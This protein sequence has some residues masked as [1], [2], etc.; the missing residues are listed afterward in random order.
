MNN[1]Q[2]INKEMSRSFVKFGLFII[3]LTAVVFL[4]KTFALGYYK[5]RLYD[6]YENCTVSTSTKTVRG[7]KGSTKTKY[8]VKVVCKDPELLAKNKADTQEG[9]EASQK[10]SRMKVK[11]NYEDHN[12]NKSDNDE[13]AEE[14]VLFSG[15]VSRAYYKHFLNYDDS[16]IAMYT[17]D[18][19]RHF[20]VWDRNCSVTE[21]EKQYRQLD[22]PVLW[23]TL[24]CFGLGVGLFSLIMGI[25]AK[26]T[27][28]NYSNDRVYESEFRFENTE[29][30]LVGMAHARIQR[31]K[32]D[33]YRRRH[34]RYRRY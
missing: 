15:Y 8:Y 16:K 3:A 7:S 19:G 24:Y 33:E 10:E 1:N 9:E 11:I 5:V 18:W 26:K 29:D 4:A 6:T 12:S 21:A 20:P 30:A 32:A 28:T 27:S 22:P 13:D 2:N 17:T 14:E 25:K 34:N 23:Q 31:E